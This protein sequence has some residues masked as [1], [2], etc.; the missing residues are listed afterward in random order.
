MI[1]VR[2]VRVQAEEVPDQ[3]IWRGRLYLVREVLDSWRERRAWW[4][5][6]LAPDAGEVEPAR[7]LAPDAL[8]GRVYRVVASPGRLAGTG[9]YDLSR[10][11]DRWHLVGLDD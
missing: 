7:L 1:E 10:S 5:D 2:E 4:R 3:F 11:G 6:V 8:E 9:V